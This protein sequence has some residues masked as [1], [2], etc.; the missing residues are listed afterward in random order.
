MSGVAGII[1]PD[2]AH[3]EK[4]HIDRV[5]HQAEGISVD[6]GPAELPEQ[7]S[8]TPQMPSTEELPSAETPSDT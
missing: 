5:E 3:I 6:Q 8:E 7:Q 4:S 1:M 2:N